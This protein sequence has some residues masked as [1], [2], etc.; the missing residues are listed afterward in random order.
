MIVNKLA[1]AA[2]NDIISGL[3]GT[4]ATINV[5]VRQL[6]D[7]LVLTRLSII[8]QYALKNLLPTKDLYYSLNCIEVDCKSLDKCCLADDSD[9]VMAHFEIP[10]I[11]T[12]AGDDAIGYIGST[13]KSLKFKVYT[14]PQFKYHKYKRRGNNKPYVYIDPTPNENNMLDGYI[15]NAPMLERLSV[16]AIFKDPRQVEQLSCCGFSEQDNFSDIA[17]ETK[18]TV[19]NKYVKYYRSLLNPP[20]PNVQ[21]PNGTL[22]GSPQPS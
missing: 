13:D 16:M 15:F 18:D 8:H 11:A 5:P 1:S 3:S 9:V 20:Y 4:T 12:V 10:Q 19:V 21:T 17:L 6:E 14:T 2:L 7:E 22:I